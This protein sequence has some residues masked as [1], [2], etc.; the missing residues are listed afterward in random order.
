MATTFSVGDR[1][2]LKSSMFLPKWM[3]GL[4]A[5]VL[6]ANLFGDAVVSIDGWGSAGFSVSTNDLELVR[7]GP[8]S[9]SQ[10]PAS[11]TTTSTTGNRFWYAYRPQ[12]AKPSVQHR[13]EA[14]ADAEA[15]RI[16][17]MYPN[18]AVYVLEAKSVY[19][20][21]PATVSGGRLA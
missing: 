5:E 10:T 4:E 11:P 3:T 15:K 1:V 14:E 8:I 9:K 21:Q 12:G 17:A 18:E 13:T 20:T 7:Q 19:T 6:G 16:A 2:R